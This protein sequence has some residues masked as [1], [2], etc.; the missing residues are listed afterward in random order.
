ME[1]NP[2]FD[3]DAAHRW[4][5]VECNNAIF[6]LLAKPD[7][8]PAETDEM[9]ACAYSALLHWSRYSGATIVN[10]IRA[11]N[12]IATALCY[13]GRTQ[14]ALYHA[15]KNYDLLMANK[16]EAADFD[17][18]YALMAMART[19]ALAGNTHHAKE[20]YNQCADA[21]ERIADPDDKAIVAQDFAAGEWYGIAP[22]SH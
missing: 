3:T 8:T 2:G 19:H 1:H 4:F 6:P 13:A 9:I 11:E 7:R 17:F 16:A 22:Q 10:I 5:G 14:Q 12:M 15:Q 20:F 18:A 21:I